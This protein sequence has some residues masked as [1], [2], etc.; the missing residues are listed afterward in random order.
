MPRAD[1]TT[2][3]ASALVAQVAYE[4]FADP[5]LVTAAWREFETSSAAS[6]RPGRCRGEAASGGQG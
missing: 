4:L 5:E 1:E 3:L 2:L 6:A